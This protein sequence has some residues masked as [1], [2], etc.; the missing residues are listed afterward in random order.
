MGQ[1]L[2]TAEIAERLGIS[3]N[4]VE[5]HRKNLA[6]KLN[7]SGAELVRLAAIHNQTSLPR[8]DSV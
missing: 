6:A 8:R 3:R 2:K 1:G 7:A 4:T 5:T